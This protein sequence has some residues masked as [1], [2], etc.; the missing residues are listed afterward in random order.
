[1]D[2]GRAAAE[3]WRV[4]LVDAQV[5]REHRPLANQLRRGDDALWRQ[6]VEAPELVIVAEE[7]PGRSF[8]SAGLD[9][10]LGVAGQLSDFGSHGR[11]SLNFS[12]AISFGCS[13][14]ST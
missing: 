3:E 10:E 7:P 8:G 13:D 12:V 14:N 4:W 11:F 5:Q 6:Q 1:M 9:G 2:A